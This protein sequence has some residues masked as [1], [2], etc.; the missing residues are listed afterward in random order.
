MPEYCKA[1]LPSP[2][3]NSKTVFRFFP[4]IYKLKFLIEKQSVRFSMNE[5]ITLGSGAGWVVWDGLR[6]SPS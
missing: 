3:R 6:D 2:Q 5:I 4:S 1:L